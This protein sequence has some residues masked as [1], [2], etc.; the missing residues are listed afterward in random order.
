MLVCAA[1]LIVTA[2]DPAA[3]AAW[4]AERAQ[5]I[6]PAL[7]VID[8]RTLAGAATLLVAALLSLL[9]FY[10]RRPYILCWVAR[11]GSDRRVEAARRA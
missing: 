2:A 7:T 4:D 5:A 9:Y 6:A 8:V 10:R 3:L 11:V 1:L